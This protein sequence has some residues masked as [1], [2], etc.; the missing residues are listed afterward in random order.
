MARITMHQFQEDKTVRAYFEDYLEAKRAQRS[1]RVSEVS[2]TTYRNKFDG[3]GVYFDF[4]IMM[5]DFSQKS[6]NEIIHNMEQGKRL[7]GEKG[8]VR[9]STISSYLDTLRSFFKWCAEQGIK[10]DIKIEKYSFVDVPKEVYTNEE[11]K[12]LLEKPNLKKCSFGEYRN[13]VIVC[14]LL[15][16]GCRMGTLINV[17]I[18]DLDFDNDMIFF[19]HMKARNLQYVPMGAEMKRI[20]QEYLK[21]R[22]G[23]PDSYLFP[24][25]DDLQLSTN[26]LQ[27]A[28]QRYNKSRGVNKTSIHL[29]RHYFAKSY[30]QNGGEVTRLQRIL[31]HKKIEM[32]IKYANLYGADTK[33][34]FE[35]YSPLAVISAEMPHKIKMR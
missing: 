17:L 19:R 33:L 32:T 11:V 14:F 8:H 31:G 30:L 4:D 35:E 15:N 12:R 20:L 13:W 5:N 1:R 7:D 21:I 34:G 6:V 2:I 10:D 28:I 22:G 25:E 3:I 26:G 9:D 16:S 18:K 27:T 23:N 29:F 24:S